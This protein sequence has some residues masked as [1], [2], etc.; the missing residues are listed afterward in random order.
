MINAILKLVPD[1]FQ[2]IGYFVQV[3]TPCWMAP[4][5]VIF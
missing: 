5:R 2:T 4:G 3:H 1:V